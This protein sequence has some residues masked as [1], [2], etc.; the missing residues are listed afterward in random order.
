LVLRFGL[1]LEVGILE[2]GAH[3]ESKGQLVM[4]LFGF[5]VLDAGKDGWSIDEVLALVD[6]GIANLTDQDNKACRGIVMGGVGPDHQDHVHDGHEEV[7]NICELLARLGQL[8]E[9]VLKGLQVLLVLIG[10]SPGRL[11]LF[12][13]LAEWASVGRLILFEELEDLLD[14]LTSKLLADEVQ[15]VRLVLPELKLSVRVWVLVTLQGTLRVLL[16]YVFDLFGPC[17][18]GAF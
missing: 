15:V 4:G 7:W 1:V 5:F 14:L 17:D 16:K 9:E 6:D 18:Y 2:L 3:I 13:K 10:F 12:L 8:L 11:H